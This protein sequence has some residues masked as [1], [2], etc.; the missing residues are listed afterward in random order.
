MALPNPGMTARGEELRDIVL[1]ARNRSFVFARD[2]HEAQHSAPEAAARHLALPAAARRSAPPAA[3]RHYYGQGQALG[4]SSRPPT[5]QWEA[6]PEAARG[7][8]HP[9][10]GSRQRVR[11]ARGAEL[12]SSG[13]LRRAPPA[14]AAGPA[15]DSSRH[16]QREHLSHNAQL[17]ARIP[18]VAMPLTLSTRCPALRVDL[19]ASTLCKDAPAPKADHDIAWTYQDLLYADGSW[20]PPEPQKHDAQRPAH[21]ALLLAPPM[22]GVERAAWGMTWTY[23]DLL[24]AGGS[25]CPP[26][27]PKRDGQRLVRSA[28]LPVPPAQ[29]SEQAALD[30][31]QLACS[32]QLPASSAYSAERSMT[33]TPSRECARL[34]PTREH[35]RMPH[36]GTAKAPPTECARLPHSGTTDVK[37]GQRARQTPETQ[38]LERIRP[39]SGV[40]GER[41][42][43]PSRRRAKKRRHMQRSREASRKRGARGMRGSAPT[44]RGNRGG[45]RSIRGGRSGGRIVMFKPYEGACEAYRVGITSAH[46]LPLDPK[47]SVQVWTAFLLGGKRARRGW[48]TMTTASAPSVPPRGSRIDGRCLGPRDAQLPHQARHTHGA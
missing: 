18:R 14:T 27:P 44:R 17:A 43:H 46:A 26:E 38:P 19:Q 45:S 8:R 37:L 36:T 13:S 5:T 40:A 42:A 35:A 32:V 6:E 15:A 12:A 47:E 30:E 20:C 25:W 4:V 41:E 33:K 23:E 11:L 39:P 29:G 48:H 9:K 31:P 2:V 24:Y 1:D 22:H 28:S 7:L 34:P 3:A 21:D 16:R 10:H